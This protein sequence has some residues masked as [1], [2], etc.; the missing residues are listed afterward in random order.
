M[1]MPPNE[2]SIS[3][4]YLETLNIPTMHFRR[5]LWHANNIKNNRLIETDS[6]EERDVCNSSSSNTLPADVLLNSAASTVSSAFD[7]EMNVGSNF[8]ICDNTVFV[9]SFT[10]WT[11]SEDCGAAVMVIVP[12]YLAK[13]A[14]DTLEKYYN[15]YN[16]VRHHLLT[17]QHKTTSEQFLTHLEAFNTNLRMLVFFQTELNI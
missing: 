4:H 15:I 13:E 5:P 8:M 10:D 9:N 16:A 2:I 14:Y 17:L 3:H 12:N 6:K 1:A 11:P 7:D